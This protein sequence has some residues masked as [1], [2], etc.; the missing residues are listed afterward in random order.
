MSYN[1][2]GIFKSSIVI[3]LCLNFIS[4]LSK[5]LSFESIFKHKECLNIDYSTRP[6]KCSIHPERDA[7]YYCEDC[8]RTICGY[9][10]YK[11]AHSK[12][13]QSQHQL[14]DIYASFNKTKN[15]NQNLDYDEK[16][17]IGYN[18]IRKTIKSLQA[19]LDKEQ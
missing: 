5:L 8:K 11:G 3:H 14:E 9:C 6:G 2:S 16:K 1:S 13:L 12:G 10:R 18:T 19:I 7:E 15:Q 17:R 4:S